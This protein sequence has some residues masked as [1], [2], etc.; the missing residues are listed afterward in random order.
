MFSD[1][2]DA[3]KIN[4]V[5]YGDP[6]SVDPFYERILSRIGNK[7]IER[8][9]ISGEKGELRYLENY[10]IELRKG[11]LQLDSVAVNLIGRHGK[12]QFEHLLN[13]LYTWA[14]SLNNEI[15]SVKDRI[16]AIKDSKIIRSTDNKTRIILWL[17]SIGVILAFLT[18]WLKLK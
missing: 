15:R 12:K 10:R 13:R 17:T 4:N 2:I 16:T 14:N 3:N 9:Q 1:F 6:S 18:L 11:I 7:F 5:R 8:S